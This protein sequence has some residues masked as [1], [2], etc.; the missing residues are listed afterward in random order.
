MMEASRDSFKSSQVSFLYKV[1]M[2][3]NH[4]SKQILRVWKFYLYLY[5]YLLSVILLIGMYPTPQ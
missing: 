5:L 3:K 4:S 2:E 1:V